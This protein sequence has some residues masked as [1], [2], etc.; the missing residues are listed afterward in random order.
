MV[1]RGMETQ[2]FGQQWGSVYHQASAQPLKQFIQDINTTSSQIY[3]V[4]TET[5]I[6]ALRTARRSAVSNATPL[7]SRLS[8]RGD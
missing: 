7:R 6:T 1:Y 4:A 5:P 8:C 3:M 2:L